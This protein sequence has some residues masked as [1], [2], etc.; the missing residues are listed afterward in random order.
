VTVRPINWLVVCGFALLAPG[1]LRSQSAQFATLS[2]GTHIRFHLNG[3]ASWVEGRIR[4][5]TPDS[6]FTLRCPSCPEAR[7]G[8][9]DI[10]ELQ[11][12]VGRQAHGFQGMAV[13]ALGSAVISAVAGEGDARIG[14]EGHVNAIPI[15]A[16]L[17]GI[18]GGLIGFVVRTTKWEPVYLPRVRP[19]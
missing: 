7:Y 11:V 14:P 12:D 1:T 13:G 2:P 6:L 15:W 17:G 3:Q 5:K 19:L 4:G 10:S 8:L 9:A 16:G 18:A